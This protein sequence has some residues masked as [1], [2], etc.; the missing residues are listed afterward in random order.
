MVC[1]E[2]WF[3][4]MEVEG[5]IGLTVTWYVLKFLSSFNAKDALRPFNRNMVCIEI[6]Y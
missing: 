4:G 1:I 2:M 5:V 3:E 6:S